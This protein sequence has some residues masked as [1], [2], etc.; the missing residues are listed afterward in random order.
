M[1]EDIR[2]QLLQHEPMRLTPPTADPGPERARPKVPEMYVNAE[3]QTDKEPPQPSSM[4]QAV[5][6]IDGNCNQ[7]YA[8]SSEALQTIYNL[9]ENMKVI[10][11]RQEEV[12]LRLE[13]RLDIYEAKE[14]E[15]EKRRSTSRRKER[16]DRRKDESH[17]ERSRSDHR[18]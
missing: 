10:N 16:G 2:P 3:V 14:K 8:Q 1:T 13:K 9:T 12:I 4:E 5:M 15:N 11:R 7:M 6:R 18:R 17:R